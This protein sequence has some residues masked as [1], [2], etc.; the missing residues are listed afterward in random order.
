MNENTNMLNK[1]PKTNSLHSFGKL[2]SKAGLKTP[3]VFKS[4]SIAKKVL[5]VD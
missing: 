5:P 3:E 2:A 1:Q 4:K